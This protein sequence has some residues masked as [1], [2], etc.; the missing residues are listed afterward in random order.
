MVTSNTTVVFVT[1]LKGGTGGHLKVGWA[2]IDNITK[3]YGSEAVRKLA[4]FQWEQIFAVKAV[5]E[6]EHLDCDLLLTRCL[7][8]MLDHTQTDVRKAIDENQVQEG[9]EYINVCISLRQK[10]WKGSTLRFTF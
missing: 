3:R 2:Y 5:V 4:Q 9:I 8:V 6:K 1:V 10:M 7:E